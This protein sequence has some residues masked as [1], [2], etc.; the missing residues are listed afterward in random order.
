MTI[1]R[2]PTGRSL[3]FG[4][5]PSGGKTGPTRVNAELGSQT[6]DFAFGG[7]LRT[8]DTAEVRHGR[9]PAEFTALGPPAWYPQR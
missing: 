5:P 6:R 2:I 4:V 7:P 9:M 3:A 1:L 8:P